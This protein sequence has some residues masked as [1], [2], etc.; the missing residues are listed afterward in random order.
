MVFI[1]DMENF[2]LGEAF[3]MVLLG[4][5][6]AAYILYTLLSLSR[7]LKI[8]KKL[9]HFVRKTAG[10]KLVQFETNENVDAQR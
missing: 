7:C 8:I 5:V 10:L 1:A 4:E 2:T 3:E 6:K 9:L